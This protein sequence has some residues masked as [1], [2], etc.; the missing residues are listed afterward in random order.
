MRLGRDAYTRNMSSFALTEGHPPSRGHAQLAT[1][2][3]DG[4]FHCL[5]SQALPD[6]L[7]KVSSPQHATYDHVVRTAL[8]ARNGPIA[9]PEEAGDMLLMKRRARCV[10]FVNTVVC[11][12]ES[13]TALVSYEPA[14]SMTYYAGAAGSD[15][16]A[17]ASLYR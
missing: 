12:V 15:R 2:C 17:L 11:P 16:S 13:A 9:T 10:N 5:V 7:E 3:I 8:D 14:V 6:A 1:W 4:I